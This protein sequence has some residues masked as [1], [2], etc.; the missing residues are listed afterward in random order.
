VPTLGIPLYKLNF[1]MDVNLPQER[2]IGRNLAPLVSAEVRLRAKVAL[3]DW[4]VK[5]RTRF[6][7]NFAM[8][9]ISFDLKGRSVAGVAWV[10]KNH[11]QLNAPMLIANESRFASEVIPHE[12]SHLLAHGMFGRD[13]APHGEEWKKVMS[14]LG[15]RA[16]ST[17][18]LTDAPG[19][20][21][22]TGYRYACAC[23]E[24]QVSTRRHNDLMRSNGSK[25][26]GCQKCGTTFRWKGASK[27]TEPARQ[28]S[29]AVKSPL[30]VR[31]PSAKMV[32]FAEVLAQRIGVLLTPDVRRSY[33]ACSAFIEKHKNA[34]VPPSPG[35]A[36]ASGGAAQPTPPASSPSEAQLRYAKSI[37]AR[38]NVAIPE[39]VLGSKKLMSEWID[40]NR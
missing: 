34:P 16:S 26:L 7:K 39:P 23:R 10:G 28:S 18:D 4:T 22:A 15:V 27:I 12:L 21:T 37:A 36:T 13:I 14:T 25:V 20:S 24:I 19:T 40:M 35:K 11:I 31:E 30:E 9:T 3:R 1:F 29:P 8:P 33:D 5:A 6:G 2:R 17:I 38:R 32:G